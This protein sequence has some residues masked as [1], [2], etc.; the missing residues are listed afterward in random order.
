MRSCVFLLV[1]GAISLAAASPKTF[2]GT[3][4]NNDLDR[5]TPATQCP[6]IKTPKFTLQ[7][8]T[9]A[10]VLTDEQLAAKYAGKKV[11]VTATVTGGN[12]LKVISITPAR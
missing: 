10:W 12:H 8:E 11:S 6:V 1:L 9:E 5:S 7:T 3:V 4:H 2:V